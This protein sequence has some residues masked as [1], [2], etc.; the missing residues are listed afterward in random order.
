MSGTNPEVAQEPGPPRRGTINDFVA[1]VFGRFDQLYKLGYRKMVLLELI[2]LELTPAYNPTANIT[3]KG[4][5]AL[6]L[7]TTVQ[8]IVLAINALYPY[9]VAD[10]EREHK[11]ANIQI[12]PTHELW[13]RFYFDKGQYGFTNVQDAEYA[14]IGK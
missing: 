4:L 13:E 14:T 5:T 7:S 9:K 6:P 8:Q 2:P 3:S 12:F 10:F 1:C 11:G